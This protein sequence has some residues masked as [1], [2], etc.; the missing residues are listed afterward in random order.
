MPR[1]PAATPRAERKRILSAREPLER[2]AFA[3]QPLEQ[4][5]RRQGRQLAQ[6]PVFPNGRAEAAISS[7]R[8]KARSGRPQDTLHPFP[9]DDGD[10]VSAAAAM[11]AL[12]RLCAIPTR[13]FRPAAAAARVRTIADLFLAAVQP[14]KPDG[15]KIHEPWPS[16]FHSR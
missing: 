1:T 6:R 13:I 5:R 4:R 11:S 14:V 15:V 3:T 2:D 12:I 7:E 8:S 10:A 9:L 16:L